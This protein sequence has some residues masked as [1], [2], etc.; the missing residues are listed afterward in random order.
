MR[1]GAGDGLLT[2]VEA[3]SPPLL[4]EYWFLSQLD[5]G[6]RLLVAPDAGTLVRLRYIGDFRS[7]RSARKKMGVK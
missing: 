7:E 3:L 2:T 6:I 1:L 4:S 5:G